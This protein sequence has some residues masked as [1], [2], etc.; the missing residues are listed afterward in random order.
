[1]KFLD[2]QKIFIKSGDG[3]A[4]CVAFRREKYI[5]LGGPDGGDGEFESPDG[6]FES[7]D[8][9]HNA[10]IDLSEPVAVLDLGDQEEL[11]EF[12]EEFSTVY[13]QYFDANVSGDF[14][15]GDPWAISIEEG[16][17]ALESVVVDMGGLVFAGDF[18]AY[19]EQ[20]LDVSPEDEKWSETDYD[21]T[22]EGISSLYADYPFLH[23]LTDEDGN[24]TVDGN[25][26]QHDAPDGNAT[27][28]GSDQVEYLL[29]IAET[30]DFEFLADGSVLLTGS[31][32]SDGDDSD[33][34]MG[35]VISDFLFDGEVYTKASLFRLNMPKQK[36]VFLFSSS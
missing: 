15:P 1:M 4:G 31:L 27:A 35:F 21:A 30:N 6:E 32:L 25:Y 8:G 17:G 12:S 34:A 14:G 28:E 5:E 7:S 23:D 9:E 29:A 26:T 10:T 13:F 2:Q 22:S 19:W 24:Q 20:V 33:T 36:H 18:V 3:G 16:T 11:A